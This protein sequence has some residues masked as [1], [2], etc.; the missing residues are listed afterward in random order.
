MRSLSGLAPDCKANI[1]GHEIVRWEARRKDVRV[2]MTVERVKM[3]G[4]CE[5]KQ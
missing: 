4:G 1:E 2:Q 5:A 3:G